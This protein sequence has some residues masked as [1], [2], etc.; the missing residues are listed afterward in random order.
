M[1]RERRGR[2]RAVLTGQLPPLRAGPASHR[3]PGAA[4]APPRR[5]SPPGRSDATS[6]E[7]RSRGSGILRAESGASFAAGAGERVRVR[8]CSDSAAPSALPLQVSVCACKLQIA[9]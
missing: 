9:R 1:C 6:R 8:L 3:D 2:G 5:P 7:C 4:P